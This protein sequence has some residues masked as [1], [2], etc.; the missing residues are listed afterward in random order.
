MALVV[1]QMF[2]E[3][4]SIASFY[5]HCGALSMAETNPRQ[6]ADVENRLVR[7]WSLRERAAWSLAS[8]PLSCVSSVTVAQNVL[9]WNY[10][11][12]TP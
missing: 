1:T 3:E 10:N 9:A 8:G 2:F 4:C 7:D 6:A 11:T 5:N 12:L